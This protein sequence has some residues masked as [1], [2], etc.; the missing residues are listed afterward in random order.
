MGGPLQH[1]QEETERTVDRRRLLRRAGTVAA[2]VAGAGVVTAVAAAP[3]EAAPGDPVVLGQS[4]SGGTATTTIAN[5]SSAQ[6]ALTL[7]NPALVGGDAGPALRLTPSGAG[8]SPLAPTGSVSADE[9]GTLWSSVQ[10]GGDPGTAFVYTNAT[11][12]MV[13]PLLEPQRVVDTR[14]AAGRV[15]IINQ[16]GNLDGSG[17]LIA[18]RTIHVNLGDYVFFGLG[19]FGNLAVANA[20]V[21]GFATIYPFGSAR[22]VASSVNYGPGIASNFFMV[23]D[24]WDPTDLDPSDAVSIFSQQTVHVILDVTGFVVGSYD[25][26]LVGATAT[27]AAADGAA[28]SAPST[29]ADRQRRAMQEVRKRRAAR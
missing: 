2:G 10:F 16:S 29:L 22:P 8:L 6:P 21:A 23:A 26:I 15:N 7:G 19:V 12:S 1:E 18:G 24:G 5:N 11:A 14:S 17:R 13:V 9:T 3:A 25:Q 28:R 4:N 20:T 27:A